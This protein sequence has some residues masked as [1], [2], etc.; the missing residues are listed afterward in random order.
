MTPNDGT[1]RTEMR[2]PGNAPPA[3]NGLLAVLMLA[4]FIV[5]F[6]TAAVVIP[7][8]AILEDLGGT[9]DMATWAYGAFVLVF[10]V[11]LLPSARLGDRYGR[12]P[13]FLAGMALFTLASLACA[14]APSIAFLTVARGVEGLGAAMA[15]PAAFAMVNTAFSGKA[16]QRAAGAHRGAFAFAA[17]SAPILSGLITWGLSWEFV[18]S[19]NVLAGAAVIV[20]GIRLVPDTRDDN[21]PRSLDVPG[22]LLGGLGVFALAFAVIE[23]TRLGWSSPPI[24][25][26]IVAAVVLLGLFVLNERRADA[27]LVDRGLLASRRFTA[28]NLARGLG[29]FASLGLFF[30]LSHLLQVQLGHSALVAGALLM[31]I[32]AGAVIVAPVSE[33]L[34][35]KT[36]VRL[37]VIPGFLLIAAGTF[38]ITLSSS[39]PGWLFFLAP[40]AIAGAGF[41]LQEDPTAATALHDV[42]PRRSISGRNISYVVYLLGITAGVAV[43]SGVWQS[44]FVANAKDALGEAGLPPAARDLSADLSS[45]GVSGDPAANITGPGA[46]RLREI[47]HTAFTDAVGTALLS[48]VAVAVL[49]ALVAVLLSPA[50]DDRSDSSTADG[51]TSD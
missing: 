41:G 20:A 4:T 5:V 23:G 37:L 18:F 49:G 21:G 13:V 39:H 42:P 44:R 12:R 17:L 36:D 43:V 14:L 11:F 19:L 33:S 8:P 38:W 30:A 25:A 31:T 35:G 15:E 10:A 32:I 46:D 1:G 28:G 9:L 51:T 2:E 34:T 45:G 47:V 24:V 7:L 40:L 50:K 29:E 16:K 22:V 27:P 26:F 6:D 3:G 48:C